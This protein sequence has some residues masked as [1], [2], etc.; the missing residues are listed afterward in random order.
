MSIKNIA[1]IEKRSLWGREEEYTKD[2]SRGP[3]RPAVLCLPSCIQVTSCHLTVVASGSQ[4]HGTSAPEALPLLS[5][6]AF[7]QAKVA[8]RSTESASLPGVLS[9]GVNARCRWIGRWYQAYFLRKQ[10][11][12]KLRQAIYHGLVKSVSNSWRLF[13]ILGVSFKDC[14]LGKVCRQNISYKTQL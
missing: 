10:S 12:W 3:A 7:I 11:T 8:V 1:K 5:C 14:S 9:L 6:K 2:A 4:R 13:I